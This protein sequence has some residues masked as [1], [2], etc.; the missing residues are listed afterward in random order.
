MLKQQVKLNMIHGKNL[1]VLALL[2]HHLFHANP[3]ITYTSKYLLICFLR[4][5]KIYNFFNSAYMLIFLITVLGKYLKKK[6][7]YFI[8]YSQN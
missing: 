7:I 2:Y 6:I 4:F 5:A 1:I 3:V 8:Y